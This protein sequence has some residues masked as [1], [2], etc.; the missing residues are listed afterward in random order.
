[1]QLLDLVGILR[2][3]IPKTS[4]FNVFTAIRCESDE[5][6]LHS[7]LIAALVDR[8]CHQ[9]ADE[10][11]SALLK[12]FDIPLHG[13]NSFQLRG[14][15]VRTEFRGIDILIT[16]SAEQAIVI[17]N[18]IYAADQPKQLR[19]YYDTVRDLGYTTIYLRYL[20]LDGREPSQQS[21]D[22]LDKLLSRPWLGN[23]SFQYEVRRWL[24]EVA[25]LVVRETG[26]RETIFQYQA[27]LDRLTG[28]GQE[29]SY[30]N[31]LVSSLLTGNNMIVARDI[32]AA[33]PQA[34]AILQERLWLKLIEALQTTH[35]TIGQCIIQKSVADPKSRQASIRK[36]YEPARK[37]RMYYGLGVSVPGYESLELWIH[38]ERALYVGAECEKGRSS[39]EYRLAAQAIKDASISGHSNENWPIWRFIREDHNFEQ[40]DE[41]LLA[42]LCNDEQRD[43]FVGVCIRA[44]AEIWHALAIR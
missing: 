33:Y 8:K 10:A 39:R 11:L 20:T 40:P 15:Q 27:V 28:Q 36:Y 19:R 12:H 6:F 31:E 17:E 13:A 1:M 30:M 32:R 4:N 24:D 3:A 21:L 25:G 44:L 38:I 43:A 26:L 14:I 7:R 37:E 22:G 18:K 5:V 23:V 9:F 16:N 29:K 42:M 35:P 34:L 41:A 2:T